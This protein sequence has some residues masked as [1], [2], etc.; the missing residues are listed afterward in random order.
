MSHRSALIRAASLSVAAL[1]MLPGA[2]GHMTNF[3]E[4]LLNSHNRERELH[5]I[6]ALEWDERLA[7]G[8]ERWATH[9]ARHDR[10]EHS[11]N[12]PGM[13]LEGENI[14]GGSHGAFGPEAMIDLWVSEKRYFKPGWFPNNSTTGRVADVSHF[15][16]VVWHGT[17]KV[18]CGLARNHE[19]DILVCR[20]SNPGNVFGYRVLKA[21]MKK[22]GKPKLAASL[23]KNQ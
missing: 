17:R 4:R 15:T 22:R 23:V 7:A 14:W 9:L 21:D 10:F 20:Y 5:R 3:E 19:R 11:P 2:Q 1:V 12:E 6:P 16:Q 8:A 13:P 18:G